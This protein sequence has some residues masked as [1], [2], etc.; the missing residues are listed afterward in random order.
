VGAASLI[1][2]F[3]SDLAEIMEVSMDQSAGQ[4]DWAV[5]GD[6]LRIGWNS[7]VPLSL[8]SGDVLIN[9]R[10]VTTGEFLQGNSIRFSLTAD[11]MNELADG[12][13]E[14]IPDAELSINTLESAALGTPD[15]SGIESLT[16]SSYPNPFATYTTLKYTLPSD[17]QVTLEISNVLGMKVATVVNE[18]QTIGTYSFKL[19]EL[20]LQP[21]VYTATIKLVTAGGDMVK[22]IKLVRNR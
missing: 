4:L 20:P 3:P 18:L 7:S 9:I 21:G 12:S 15:L 10:L 1:L 22:T 5:N 19:D 16:L 14:T 13:F 11:P 6:E 2:N 8:A 17:G